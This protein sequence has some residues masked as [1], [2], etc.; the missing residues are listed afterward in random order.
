MARLHVLCLMLLFLGLGATQQITRACP[1]VKM[2]C[3]PLRCQSPN[4]TFTEP[5][6]GP[7]PPLGCPQCLPRCPVQPSCPRLRCARGTVV[8]NP[9]PI[10][11]QQ[12]QRTCVSQPCG[13]CQPPTPRP[14]PKGKGKLSTKQPTK[15]RTTQPSN[16]GGAF[17]GNRADAARAAPSATH[18]DH[19]DRTA[20]SRRRFVR[21]S[22]FFTSYLV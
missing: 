2:V 1:M 8:Q 4:V 19:A 14:T 21:I 10:R 18:G 13:R 7:C 20:Q 22:L 15:G 5:Q 3:P 12:Q 6:T 11:S 17:A 16:P 9:P